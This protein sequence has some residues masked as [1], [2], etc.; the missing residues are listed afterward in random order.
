MEIREY[1]II[2]FIM[3]TSKN[4]NPL[5]IE[6]GADSKGLK[7]KHAPYRRNNWKGSEEIQAMRKNYKERHQN[8]TFSIIPKK[9]EA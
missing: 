3:T 5:T 1:L 6:I 8:K 7:N 9:Y 4:K 2:D